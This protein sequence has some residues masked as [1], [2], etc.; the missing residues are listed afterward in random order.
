MKSKHLL[1][2]IALLGTLICFSPAIAQQRGMVN[3]DISNVKADIA[4][5]LNMNVNQIPSSVQAPV[6]V[7]AN[8]CGMDANTLSR[9]GGDGGT[10]SCQAQ[11]TSNDL[12]RIVRQQMMGR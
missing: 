11:T 12:N 8:V 2:A 4:S 3:V 1:I 5:N 6:A 10:T 9:Q 7:A